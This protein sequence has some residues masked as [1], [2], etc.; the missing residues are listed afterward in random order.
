[1]KAKS[2]PNFKYP[3]LKPGIYK[4]DYDGAI[5]TNEIICTK[6]IINICTDFLI[7]AALSTTNT[8]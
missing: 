5:M 3:V 2:I 7:S 6:S 1:M 4:W 8:N